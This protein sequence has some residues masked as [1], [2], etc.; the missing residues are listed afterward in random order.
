LE[1]LIPRLK[2]LIA[3][4]LSGRDIQLAVDEVSIRLIHV[5]GDGMLA[6]VELEINAAAFAE[7]VEK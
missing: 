4:E 3:K 5:T 1:N 7:R 2:K 6:P